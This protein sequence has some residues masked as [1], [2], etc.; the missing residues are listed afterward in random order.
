MGRE[1]VLKKSESVLIAKKYEFSEKGSIKRDASYVQE[2][3]RKK[4]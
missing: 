3:Y 1:E 4:Y 2:Q